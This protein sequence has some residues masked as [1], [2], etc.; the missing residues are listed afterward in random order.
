MARH[1]SFW[2]KIYRIFYTL[3]LRFRLCFSSKWPCCRFKRPI[4][5]L[6]QWQ[7]WFLVFLPF[8]PRRLWFQRLQFF[9]LGISPLQSLRLGP[10]C[11]RLWWFSN[12]LGNWWIRS[13]FWWV[14]SIWP[15]HNTHGSLVLSG[16]WLWF[17]FS[18]LGRED[19]R[20]LWISLLL[21]TP[22]CIGLGRR[23]IWW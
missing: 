22:K 13:I 21:M 17:L 6:F 14:L 4:R 11:W 5:R 16:W 1:F 2:R 3:H 8:F 12:K 18:R 19:Q 10:P 9:P 23:L 7:F 20:R 15:L